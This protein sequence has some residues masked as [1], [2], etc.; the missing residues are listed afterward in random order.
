MP[1]STSHF[2]VDFDNA[3]DYD[4]FLGSLIDDTEEIRKLRHAFTSFLGATPAE[5]PKIPPIT[6]QI[7]IGK[8]KLPADF[9]AFR[10]RLLDL[11]PTWEHWFWTDEEVRQFD[12][13]DRDLYESSESIGHKVD[14]LRA[15]ILSRFGGV[16]V[17]MD[18][19]FLASLEPLHYLCDL[20]CSL[21]P[22][23]SSFRLVPSVPTGLYV[24]NS[25]IGCT[26]SHPVLSEY[27]RLMRINLVDRTP[28]AA[29][30]GW[31]LRLQYGEP[32]LK[33]LDS[34]S[35]VIRKTYIPLTHAFL[36]TGA[37]DGSVDVA[38]PPIF[39]NPV[40]TVWRRMP[41]FRLPYS[42]LMRYSQFRLKTLFRRRYLFESVHERSLS[43]HHS[44]GTWT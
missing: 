11:H 35:D 2:N 18:Y 28:D 37:R 34:A 38:L 36:S 5:E 24:C 29:T 21:R 20:Y 41:W 25:L 23:P 16:Y 27:R 22:M 7:W 43:I 19:E 1:H 40:D 15:S 26:P 8:K 30:R 17:D 31:L 44:R 9:S 32:F 13:L 33:W 14:I 12:F 6:H 39:F 3:C 4:G 42:V 10:R